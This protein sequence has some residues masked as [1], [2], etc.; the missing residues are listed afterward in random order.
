MVITTQDEYFAAMR[1]FKAAMTTET[2]R[3]REL[4]ESM[5]AYQETVS[6]EESY[7]NPLAFGKPA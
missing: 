4:A 5:L 6:P 2:D 7:L 3:S 1:E